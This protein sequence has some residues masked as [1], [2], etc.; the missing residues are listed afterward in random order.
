M[1]LLVSPTATEDVLEAI[2]WNIQHNRFAIARSLWKA[3]ELALQKIEADPMRYPRFDTNPTQMDVREFLI[4][5]YR[6]RILYEVRA[7]EVEVLVVVSTWFDDSTI[8][9]RLRSPNG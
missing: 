9:T 5:R 3:W 4:R 2:D 7:T 6:L 1:K 8:S